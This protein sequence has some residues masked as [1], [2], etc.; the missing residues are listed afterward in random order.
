MAPSR[1]KLFIFHSLYLSFLHHISGHV[2]ISCYDITNLVFYRRFL[3][4]I[5]HLPLMNLWFS[6]SPIALRWHAQRY[7]CISSIAN[8]AGILS[9]T[10]LI[11]HDLH[12]YILIPIP[13]YI[14]HNVFL[15]VLRSFS[16][17]FFRIVPAESNI[18]LFRG[19]AAEND[20]NAGKCWWKC[21]LCPG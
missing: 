7:P 13:A 6:P 15:H 21:P 20:R 3:F 1:E 17:K 4:S 16:V 11:L 19:N 9:L 18:R 12:A 5:V 2:L 14:I 10:M 8:T